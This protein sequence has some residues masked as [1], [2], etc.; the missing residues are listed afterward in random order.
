MRTVLF[1][2]ACFFLLKSEAQNFNVRFPDDQILGG[3]C[4]FSDLMAVG[5]PEFFSNDS[6]H[7][8]AQYEDEVFGVTPPGTCFTLTRTWLVYDSLSWHPGDTVIAVPNPR[9]KLQYDAPENLPGPTVSP[10]DTAGNPWSATV[11]VLFYTDTQAVHFNTFWTGAIHA[12]HYTQ[13]LYVLDSLPPEIANCPMDTVHVADLS[14]NDT[15]LWHEAYWA[16]PGL[17][18]HDLREGAADISFAATDLCSGGNIGG[19]YLLFLDLDQNGTQETVVSSNN[20]YPPGSLGFNNANNANYSGGEPRV[21]D[22]RPV[23][24]SQKYRFGVVRTLSGQQAVFSLGWY[25]N[26]APNTYVT[27]QLPPGTH[28]IEWIITD[29][30]GNSSTCQYV[31]TIT[32]PLPTPGGLHDVYIKFPD[33][34]S[35]STCDG[36]FDFG[37]PVFQQPD[38]SNIEVIYED[39]EIFPVPDACII[40]ERNWLIRNPNVYDPAQPCVYVPNPMPFAL[41]NN[42][43]NLPGPVVAPLGTAAPWEPSWVKI[44]AADPAPTSYSSFWSNYANCYQYTQHIKVSD[45]EAPVVLPFCNTLP[46][47][48]NDSSGNDPQ[49]WNAA[50]W[51]DPFTNNHDLR[52]AGVDLQLTASDICTGSNIGIGYLLF[53]DLDQDGVQE[54]VVSNNALLPPGMIRFGNASTPGLAGGELRRFDQR[55]LPEDQLYVFVNQWIVT[56]GERS[57]SIRW[58]AAG[59]SANTMLP[60][61][62]PGSHRI[63]WTIDDACGNQTVCEYLL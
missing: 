59:G 38:S 11:S 41:P 28:K 32:S 49:L 46:Q 16:E 62:P 14:D 44:Q 27:P 25:T 30:C 35:A 47:E 18:G 40:I 24:S 50:Y 9:P 29:G 2:F 55:T 17:P 21:F 33:D 3:V 45:T 34:I 36:S 48:V 15:L 19:E 52:E 57:L 37:A 60:Q 5:Q 12:Y 54:S 51:Q 20:Y 53:L 23:P 10:V 56:G 61:L 39:S 6:L 1:L 58:G 63:R 31:F 42:P 26:A 13:K 8:V 7:L 4:S 43:Q 22:R